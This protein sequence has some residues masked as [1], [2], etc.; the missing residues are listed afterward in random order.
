VAAACA[1]SSSTAA[2]CRHVGGLSRGLRACVGVVC[3]RSCCDM[4]KGAAG[5]R[6]RAVQSGADRVDAQVDS[7]CVGCNKEVVAKLNGSQDM[8]MGR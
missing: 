8:R 3:A 5:S 6:C 1:S 4:V 7:G 2:R